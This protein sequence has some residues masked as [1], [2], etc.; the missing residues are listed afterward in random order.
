[1]LEDDGPR[2]GVVSRYTIDTKRSPAFKRETP[3]A[4]PAR[5][6][7]GGCHAFAGESMVVGLL[8][9]ACFCCAKAWHPSAVMVLSKLKDD[10]DRLIAGHHGQ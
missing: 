9:A 7:T 5:F 1:M 6:N 4:R 8:L 10:F 2:A 3:G